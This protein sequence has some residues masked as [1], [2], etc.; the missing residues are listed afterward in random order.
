[1]K[2]RLL[3]LIVIALLVEL[4]MPLQGQ[5]LKH[6]E[7]QV[8]SF[9]LYDDASLAKYAFQI[10]K[11]RNRTKDNPE[12]WEDIIFVNRDHTSHLRLIHHPGDDAYDMA[13]IEVRQGMPDEDEDYY[14]TVPDKVFMT[15]HGIMIGLKEN[16]VIDIQGVPQEVFQEGDYKV[17]R[18]YDDNRKS[19]ILRQYNQ[20][21]YI[22]MFWF[23][24]GIL[25]RYS[26]GFEYP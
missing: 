10:D 7:T 2:Y 1:M 5:P 13:G 17:Y 22:I 18:Y 26:F 24:D 11:Q 16:E 4:A 3:P 12:D 14:Y 21:G 6:Y 9:K 15:P 25:V 23:R 19:W 8:N 20:V